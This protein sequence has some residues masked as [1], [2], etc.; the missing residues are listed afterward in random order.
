MQQQFSLRTFGLLVALITLCGSATAWDPEI[1]DAPK[2]LSNLEYV[3]GSAIQLSQF[4]GHPL[5]LYFGADW[6]VPCVLK[7]KPAVLATNEKYKS[8]GLKLLFISM[9]DNKFRETKIRES[10]ALGIPFAMAKSELCPPGKCPDGLR[11]LGDFGRIYKFPTAIVVGADGKVTARMN[12][13]SGIAD[14]LDAAVLK[15]VK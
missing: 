13:G 4:L 15:V 5:V 12:G 9:D 8:R 6:C 1:G 3:D 11:N 7:G 14:N 10:Q 2:A